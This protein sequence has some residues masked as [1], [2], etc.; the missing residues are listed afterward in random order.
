MRYLHGR[1]EN[2]VTRSVTQSKVVRVQRVL[3]CI[4]CHLIAGEPSLVANDSG[5]VKFRPSKIDSAVAVQADALM[6]VSCCEETALGSKFVVEREGTRGMVNE[7][8][9]ANGD[10]VWQ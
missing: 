10:T 6:R 1:V 9:I 8:S 7:S 3:L 4:E 5:S 2:K